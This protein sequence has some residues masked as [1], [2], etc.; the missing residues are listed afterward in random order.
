[1]SKLSRIL[2][3]LA[4]LGFLIPLNAHALAKAIKPSSEYQKNLQLLHEH[5]KGT[6]VLSHR[7][8]IDLLNRLAIY[9]RFKHADSIKVYVD[10]ALKTNSDRSYEKGYIDSHT[11]LAYYHTE[12]GNYEQALRLFKKTRKLAEKSSKP[13]LL[14]TVLRY[15]GLYDM[16]TGS[17]KDLIKHNYENIKLCRENGL[18][19]DEAALRH[20]LGFTYSR[21]GMY[22][23]AHKEYVIADSL[24]KIVGQ[25]HNAAYT[26]SNIALNAL[27]QGDMNTFH[28]YNNSSLRELDGELDP[29]WTSRAC[30]VYAQYYLKTKKLDSALY[31]IDQ[32]QALANT[33]EN[34]RDQLEL[35]SLYTDIYLGMKD[36]ENAEAS[37]H[38]A[39]ELS[40]KF[41]DSVALLQAYERYKDIAILQGDKE[42]TYEL[43]LEYT[44][45]KD[46]FDQ[47]AAHKSLEFLKAHKEYEL[48][49][50]EQQSALAQKNWVIL[51]ILILLLGLC[52]ILHLAR[53]NYL[54]QKNA[55]SQLSQLNASKDKLFSIISHDLISPVNTLKEMLALYHD[56]VISEQQVLDSIPRLKSRVEISSFALNNLLYWAQT[57][58]SGFRANPQEV[59]LKER[60]ALT[61]DLFEEEI[62]TKNLQ[63][64]CSI[65]VG[66]QIWF[67]INHFDVILRNLV[68]NAI[69]FTPENHKIHFDVKEQGKEIMFEIYNEGSQIPTDVVYA[70]LEDRVYHSSPG[71][72]QEK[73]TGIGLRI[74]KELAE[75]NKGHLEI[76]ASK[77]GT[78]VK[79]L[80]P[81]SSVL[82]AVS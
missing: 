5:Q 12:K 17:Q 64:E 4:P 52:V 51:G 10:L 31:W 14:V 35:Y 24:W 15:W 27:N 61:C 68:S 2:L 63:I 45:L 30:R 46:K 38:G 65:P 66:Y 70:L 62:K 41:K 56:N 72:N 82:K 11:Y 19:E 40:R 42:K 28:Q 54:N 77:S 75:L 50:K 53:K 43:L 18:T 26:R 1:M 69:K 59:N 67:D 22:E 16:Y 25:E 13:E 49:R 80:F 73:G 39:L 9:H 7:D 76:Q 37:V 21:Y 47:L 48:E 33:L 34:N 32:S 20:N 3:L 58:M 79:M 44:K 60:A 6:S 74:S 81:K 78:K 57:Q 8:H 29:L 23:C 55:N 36:L 71:T